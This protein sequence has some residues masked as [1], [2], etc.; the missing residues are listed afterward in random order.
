MLNNLSFGGRLSS[1]RKINNLKQ[2]DIAAELNFSDKTISSWENDLSEPGITEIKK[3]ADYFNVSIG[4]LLTG[5]ISTQHDGE[6]S[7][8]IVLQQAYEKMYNETYTF[9]CKFEHIDKNTF[10]SLF[11]ITPNAA[12]CN[13]KAIIKHGNLE[14]FKKINENYD[15]YVEDSSLSNDA[16]STNSQLNDRV[17]WSNSSLSNL[18]KHIKRHPIELDFSDLSETNELSF[19]KYALQVLDNKIAKEKENDEKLKKLG[20]NFN[21]GKSAIDKVSILCNA[22]DNVL[23]DF[24]NDKVY[25]IILFLL[26]NGAYIRQ[27][28]PYSHSEG[29]Q[30]E[31]NNFMTNF[32]K[33]TILNYKEIKNK[34]SK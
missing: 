10:E 16:N 29:Y 14:L 7:K 20:F 17:L 24:K 9:V 5:E 26:D 12:L 27:Y 4:F 19:Y 13:L 28:L 30:V 3:L 22:L 32:V 21:S 6:L 15:F 25:D 34:L 8:K 31:K 2:K 33:A 1:I 23:F 18:K 11:K